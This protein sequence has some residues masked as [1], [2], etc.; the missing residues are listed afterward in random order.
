MQAQVFKNPQFLQ[1]QE[2]MTQ[3]F[4]KKSEDNDAK[5]QQV[6]SQLQALH[7]E[8]LTMKSQLGTAAKKVSERQEV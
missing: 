3:Y 1:M 2:N 6:L 5:S 7:T 8:M 4:A